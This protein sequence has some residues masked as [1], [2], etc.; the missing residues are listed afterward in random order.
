[1]HL[2]Y[3]TDGTLN[4]F[5]M[6]G[7]SENEIKEKVILKVLESNSTGQSK[8][9]TLAFAKAILDYS[10]EE[11]DEESTEI[12]KI[13]PFMI[14]SPFTELSDGNLYKSAENIHLFSSQII[15]M[16][17]NDSLDGVKELLLPYVNNI[18]VLEKQD[19]ESYSFV[20]DGE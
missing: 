15:L 19:N 2:K 9:N 1:M 4:A 6:Q 11:R 10:N 17:S 16:I 20:K 5:I 18:K 14:D 8:I 3:Q 13:Y 12:T 7:L